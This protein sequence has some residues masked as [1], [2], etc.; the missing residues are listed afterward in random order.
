NLVNDI[1]DFSKLRN[2]DLRIQPAPVNVHEIADVVLTLCQTL[3][4]D[5]P[6]ELLNKIKIDLPLVMADENRLQQILYNLIGNAIKYT[7]SGSVV[8]NAETKKN[9]L[10]IYVA[11]TGHGI[12]PDQLDVIF[13]PFH[14]E[15][16]QLVRDSQG[17][18]IG[19]SITK[20]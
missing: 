13:D 9:F 3:V 2:N 12:S 6:I 20:K 18:G 7:D 16:T 17:A 4:K 10:K 8:I 11:D 14:Q 5:K 1:L 15:N 19:L